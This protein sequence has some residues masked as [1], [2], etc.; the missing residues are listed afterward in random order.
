MHDF[1]RYSLEQNFADMLVLSTGLAAAFLVLFAVA[2]AVARRLGFDG[3]L[4][5]LGA[6]TITLVLFVAGFTLFEAA[7]LYLR[8]NGSGIER[9]GA[10]REQFVTLSKAGF[11][12][13]YLA[14][15]L[16]GTAT[17][18]LLS[19][20]RVRHPGRMAAAVGG[21][22]LVFLL[23]ALPFAEFANACNIGEAVFL[24]ASC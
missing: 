9:H 8:T 2:I 16:I 4:P 3:A 23:L 24:D 14:T 1:V 13:V 5:L 18:Y 15:A 11:A 6:M 19:R 20:R 12:L 22:V 7:A 17:G 21:A 10:D